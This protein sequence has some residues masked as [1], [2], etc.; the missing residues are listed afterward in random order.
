MASSRFPAL[1]SRNF[2]IFWI[3]QF[4]SLI[5]TWMQSTTQ[6]YLAYRL[7][8]QPIYLGLLGFASSLPALLITLPTGVFVERIDKRRT[9]IVMQAIMMLQAFL[10]AY[11]ALTGQITIWHM[12][13]L[14][15]VLGTANIIEVTARQSMLI[16]LV[17]RDALPNAIALNSTV[18]NMARILGPSLAAP[19]LVL[20]QNQGEGWA[21]FANGISYF[22]VIIGLFMINTR[23]KIVPAEQR[24]PFKTDFIAGQTFI[25][26]TTLVWMLILLVSVP[27]FFGFPFSQL[28][29]VFARDVLKTAGDTAANVAT[30]NSLL[31]TFQGIGALVAA[32][33]LAYFSSLRHKGLLLTI[34]QITFA[35]G[36]VALSQVKTIGIALPII[37]VIGWGTVTQLALTNTLIQL[38]VPDDLRGRVISTYLWAMQGV[39]PFGSLFLG[40]LAQTIG[41]PTAVLIGGGVTVLVVSLAHLLN[42][43]VR[44]MVA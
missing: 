4:I 21:F 29:P 35:L 1:A 43:T 17:D 14:S 37:V 24:T 27:G 26:N 41:A 22:F 30:R 12:I 2:R 16:E 13:A 3:G 38:S 19:F 44:R 42:P 9:V 7:T 18:F 15:F 28:I 32:V 11:L 10:M 8:S 5:G 33:T 25:R 23:S 31:V 34:G 36:L 40:W 39:A 20:L 6:P